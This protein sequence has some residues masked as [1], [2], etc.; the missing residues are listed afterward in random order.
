VCDR[1]GY[2]VLTTDQQIDRLS[3]A[4]LDELRRMAAVDLDGV[5][6]ETSVIFGRDRR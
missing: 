6:V 2:V 3:L 1:R 5:P 4:T